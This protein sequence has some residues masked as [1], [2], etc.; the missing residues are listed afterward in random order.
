MIARL[1][2]KRY[3]IV[4]RAFTLIELLVVIAIIAILA[5]MLLPAL[6]RAKLKATQAVCLSN[7]KQLGLAYIMYSSDNNEKIV[8]QITTTSPWSILTGGGFWTPPNITGGMTFDQA[9][10]LVQTALKNAN[11]LYSFAPNT[12]VYH[13]PGDVRY[14]HNKPGNGWGYDSYSRTQNA[15]GEGYGNFWGQGSSTTDSGGTYS[16]LSQ[17]SNASQTFIF[18][19]DTDWRGFNTGTFVL[20]W[21]LPAGS[22]TWVDPPAMYHGNVD[23]SSFGDGHAEFHKWLNGAIVKAGKNAAL[24]VASANFTG[25]TT[26]PDY[27]YVHNNW[28]YPEWK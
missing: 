19:E 18:L 12:S 26:G 15:G 14:S 3:S 21:N 8:G 10:Q 6:A 25:P 2:C 28:H 27:N 24:G 13:C 9:M 17:M 4:T 5:A 23:T 20:N 16:K 7:Q 22:F 11:P 1:K